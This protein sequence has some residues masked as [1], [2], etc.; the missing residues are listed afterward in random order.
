LIVGI[1][2]RIPGPSRGRAEHGRS[3]R[4]DACVGFEREHSALLC[5]GGSSTPLH[6]RIS[7]GAVGWINRKSY[8][9]IRH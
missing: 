7:A 9:T 8:K 4:R 3:E 5:C 1:K 6:Q 2:E